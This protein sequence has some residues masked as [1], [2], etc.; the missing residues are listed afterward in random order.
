MARHPTDRRTVLVTAG[1]A[2]VAAAAGPV[3]AQPKEVRGTVTSGDGSAIPAGRLVLTLE[4]PAVADT[5]GR[6]VAEARLDS[7]GTARA[8]PYALPCPADAAALRL[9][10]RLERADGW[11]LARGSATAHPAPRATD[12]AL[13]PV[14]Y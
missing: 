10:A 3:A 8:I 14:M 11:L 1:A 5:A 4:D 12:V 2:A 9:V 6:R 13:A 7:D